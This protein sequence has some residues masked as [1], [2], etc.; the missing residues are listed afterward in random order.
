MDFSGL[1]FTSLAPA[2][3]RGREHWDLSV[4]ESTGWWLG[5]GSGQAAVSSQL[6]NLGKSSLALRLSFLTWKVRVDE[7]VCEL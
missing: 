1:I 4:V 6:G 7:M 5:L 3:G 2:Q